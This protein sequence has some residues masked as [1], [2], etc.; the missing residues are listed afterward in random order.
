M[1]EKNSGR[2]ASKVITTLDCK[3]S[4]AQFA[5]EECGKLCVLVMCQHIRKDDSTKRDECCICHFHIYLS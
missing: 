1:T 4:R 2:C 3:T 5:K